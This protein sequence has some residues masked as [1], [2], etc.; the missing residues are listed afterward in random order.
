MLYGLLVGHPVKGSIFAKFSRN[1]PHYHI[2]VRRPDAK[3]FDIA[4]NNLTN[5][6]YRDYLDRFRY[7]ADE[8]GRN[9]IFRLRV[10]FK[11]LT[12]NK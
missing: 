5:V 4:V 12:N 1:Q 7:F 2:D 3:D 9:I 8:P 11:I 10:P 6:A